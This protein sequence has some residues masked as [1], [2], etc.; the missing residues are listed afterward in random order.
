VPDDPRERRI[1]GDTDH[2]PLG[3][4]GGV[5]QG[6][7]ARARGRRLPD[8]AVRDKRAFLAREGGAQ[9]QRGRA[10]RCGGEGPE[11]PGIELYPSKYTVKV[12]GEV[13]KLTR[14]EFEILH[15]FM[16]YPEK[17]FTRDNIIDSI[18]GDDVYVIDRTVDVHV[19]NLRKKLGKYKNQI[20][21]FSGVGYGIKN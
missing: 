3:E 14:T 21:T 15:L 4:V 18:R 11:V 10:F 20:S 17:V 9:A 19:M 16:R 7:G 5:R 6:P 12:D 13:V 2:L 1:L 8:E